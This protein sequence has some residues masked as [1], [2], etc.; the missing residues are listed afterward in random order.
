[1]EQTQFRPFLVLS[2]LF[3]IALAIRGIYF[4]E[5]AQIPYFDTVLP[6]YDHSNFD[7][8]A[9]SF[10]GGDGLARSDNNSYSPLY[11]YF[12]GSIYYLFG[13]NF[14]V[15]YGLQFTLGAFGA[16]LIFLIGKRLFDARVGLLAFAMFS[17]YSTEIIY[18]GII[19]RAAFITFLGILSFYMLI[20]LQEYSG[21]LM[22]IGCALVLSL[23]FQSR[24]NTFLCLPVVIF[25]IHKYVVETWE[26]RSRLKGWGMFLIPLLLSFIP[27]LVQ[28]Y[29][30]HGRIVFFDSSGP[31]AFLAGNFIDYPGAG[32]D[33]KLLVEFQKDH[34]LENLS[35]VSFI[36]QQIM[37]EPIGFLKMIWRKLFFYFNDLEGASNLSIY[38]YLENSKVLPFVISHFSFFSS[39]GLMGVVLAIQKREKIFLLYAFL[40]GLILSVV[41]FHVVSRF[42]VPSTPYLILFAAYAVGRFCTW[43]SQKKYTPIAIF[44]V[45]FLALFYELRAPEDFTKVRYVDYCNWSSAYLTEEKWFDVDKAETYAIQCL[46]SKRKINSDLGVTNVSL[47]SIYKLYGSYLIQRQDKEAEKILKHAFSVDPFDSEL[48]RLYSDFQAE[49]NSTS[50]A[51]RHLHISRI[52]NKNDREPLRS[53]VDLYYSSNSD[54]GRILVALKVVLSMENDAKTI[55]RVNDEILRLKALLEKKRDEIKLSAAKARKY[56]SEEKWKEAL[57]E[58]KNLNAFNASDA[59]LLIEQG[60]VYE[61]LNDEER[62]MDSFYDALLVEEI[63]PELNKN[64]GNYYL[65]KKDLVPAILHWARYLETSSHEEEYFSIQERLKFYSYQLKMKSLPKHIFGLSREQNRQL[66]KIYRNMKVQFG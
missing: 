19:L 37:M 5:L 3:F 45:V 17:L 15:V 39:L 18:E 6:V 33:L 32:F 60:T 31:T 13:R 49:R 4:Y 12:L 23:F 28:C 22:L 9:L 44:V 51:I 2:G 63:N 66:Y 61:Y 40:A 8:G 38:L 62:A 47:A 58:Y 1:M 24:P 26:P 25:Y 46:E 35:P 36:F 27:L 7:Q 56:F 30:V 14:Y 20:R 59:K 55:Q 48:Y 43:W 41:L 65:S 29:L 21:P 57:E 11:K 50:K 52:A 53:L 16:V 34:Q 42:R 54:P 10:A 64:M